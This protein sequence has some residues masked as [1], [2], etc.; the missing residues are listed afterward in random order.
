MEESILTSTK[1]ILGL[2]E[3]H[4]EFDLDVITHINSV[5]SD[6]T[7]LGVGPVGGFDIQDATPDWTSYIADD[8]VLLNMIKT[9][10]YLRVRHLHDPPT[11]SFVL[12]ALEKQIEKME[13]RINVHRESTEWVDPNPA[14][15]A[16]DELQELINIVDSQVI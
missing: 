7:Q 5:F 3:D 10:M 12:S 4:T 6:L 13:W 1:K 14:P 15:T 2:P 11:T 8:S 9:Y 16:N